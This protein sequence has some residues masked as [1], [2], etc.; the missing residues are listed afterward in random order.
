[1]DLAVEAFDGRLFDGLVHPLD[2][3]VGP[4]MLGLCEAMIGVG[5]DAGQLEA[6]GPDRLAAL[7]CQLDL[8]DR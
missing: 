6:M 5:L 7:K 1:M 8:G 4:G 2:L 3:A